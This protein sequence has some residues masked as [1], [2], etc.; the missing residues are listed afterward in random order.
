MKWEDSDIVFLRDYNKKSAGRFL[1]YLKSRIPLCNGKK[2]EEVALQAMYK[3]GCENIIKEIE[4]MMTD[5]NQA[6]D[7]SSGKFVEM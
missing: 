3:E 4:S 7:A 1:Q 6:F 2:V 5:P